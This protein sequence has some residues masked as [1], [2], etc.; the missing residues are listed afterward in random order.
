VF[1]LS[2]SPRSFFLQVQNLPGDITVAIA[3]NFVDGA[4]VARFVSQLLERAM[5]T[6]SQTAREYYE[7][8]ARTMSNQTAFP[9]W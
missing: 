9:R 1:T 2:T 5:V 8:I 4:N 7:L 3:K 6:E